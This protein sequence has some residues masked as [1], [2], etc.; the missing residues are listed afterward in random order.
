MA[1]SIERLRGG[2]WLPL[3]RF[4]LIAAIV[5]TLAAQTVLNAKA[6]LV[7]AIVML[8]V[9]GA[10]AAKVG[11]GKRWLGWFAAGLLLTVVGSV[12]MSNRWAGGLD[13]VQVAI[14]TP[15][16]DFQTLEAPP[17]H[18]VP[19]DAV[20]ARAVWAKMALH[21]IA[22]H[23]FGLGYGGDAFGRYIVMTGGPGGALSSH[24][25]WLDFALANGIPGL[26]LLLGLFWAIMQ[27]GWMAFLAGNPAGAATLLVSVNYAARTAI[28]GN[29]SGSRLIGLAFV[30]AVLWT[31]SAM[32]SR[33]TRP[34]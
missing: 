12:V 3:N 25:G 20:H 24:S 26:L 19:A 9:A 33:A 17:Q 32:S 30:T 15:T 14:R 13:A 27:R 34:D 7:A 18:P 29:L 6:S 2:G 22:E 8:L 5:A 11:I 1:E 28:D 23:P 10:M 4:W 31:L 21:G 16:S